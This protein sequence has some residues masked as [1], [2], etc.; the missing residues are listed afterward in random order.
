[1]DDI[2]RW[3]KPHKLLPGFPSKEDVALGEHV[4][5]MRN[6]HDVR[7]MG[8][9]LD[10]LRTA[11]GD[12]YE[13]GEADDLSHIAD[14][15]EAAQ[16]SLDAMKVERSMPRFSKALASTIGLIRNGKV[17]VQTATQIAERIG[18]VSVPLAH[19]DAVELALVVCVDEA[20]ALDASSWAVRKI[21]K[22]EPRN[23]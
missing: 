2:D 7:L 18:D 23:A 9:V 19:K 8:R 22:K 5:H 17:S 11:L 21:V 12:V 10:V 6:V 13:L 1:M 16:D 4:R 3:L 20:L 15:L 14:A